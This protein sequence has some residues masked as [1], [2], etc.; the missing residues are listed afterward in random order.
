MGE[1]LGYAI[2]DSGCAKTVCGNAWIQSYCDTLSVQDRQYLK[3]VSSDG[4]FRF[5]DGQ[6][7][8][9][10]YCITIP[11]YVNDS[12]YFLTTDVVSCDV[13]LLLS[14]ESLEK[15]NAIIDFQKAEVTI[16]GHCIP[17]VITNSG[18][19]C[20][21]LTRDLSMS[22][23]HTQ[24]VLFNFKLHENGSTDESLLK[25]KVLKLHKQFAHPHP[26]RLIKLLKEADIDDSTVFD[27]VKDVSSSC[28][29]CKRCKKSPLRPIVG[30]PLAR[31]LNECIAVDLKQIGD[32]FYFLH[33]VDHLTRFSQACVI[34]SKKKGIIVQALCDYWVRIFGPPQKIL[35]DNGGEFVNNEILDFA[36]KFN[37]DLKTTAAESAWSNGLVEKHN[38]ILGDMLD[39]VMKDTNCCAEIALQWAV[40]AKNC[41][42]NVFGFS[43]N[44]LVFGKNPSFPSVID[45]RPPAN[46]PTSVSRYLSDILNALHSA[47]N[48]FIQQESSEKLQRALARKTRTY[49]D[50]VYNLGDMVYYFRN[51]SSYWHGPA[52]IIGRD[53]QQFLL[54]QGG[55]YIRVHPSRM[56][57]L[58]EKVIEDTDHC[59]PS[60]SDNSSKEKPSNPITECSSDSDD[61]DTVE[62]PVS[63][64]TCAPS[65]NPETT[66]D[67]LK[68][69]VSN[70][71]LPKKGSNIQFKLPE[72]SEWRNGTVISRGGKSS[73]ANWHFLNVQ[74]S[75]SN[76]KCISFKNA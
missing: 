41:L 1:T 70:I 39:K 18:H 17:A 7:Y 35:S 29:I 4:R 54:K 65:E 58:C 3:K 57:P 22:S 49:S 63:S 33:I 68:K 26:D 31:D 30:F 13:P 69:V 74:E 55:S 6:V 9:S 25:K 19:Y 47:R 24:T 28:E 61:S 64:D 27:L 60:C 14:R 12:R 51:N 62:S 67:S 20:L 8:S 11:F 76:A 45:N 32:S 23:K 42:M 37:V 59:S 34:K 2:L 48:A 40:A 10:L 21:P 75:G 73:T 71:D 44:V 72:D 15:A 52:K 66:N 46:N 38:G 56:Q 36:E 50:T 43:P 5:G 53:C 16:L